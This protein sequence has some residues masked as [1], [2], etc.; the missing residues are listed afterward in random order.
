MTLIRERSD[1][2]LNYEAKSFFS[3]LRK[4]D[5][6]FS[7]NYEYIDDFVNVSKKS[8]VKHYDG[9]FLRK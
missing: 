2:G 5:H 6:F 8:V 7:K 3:L 1:W 9:A 4:T